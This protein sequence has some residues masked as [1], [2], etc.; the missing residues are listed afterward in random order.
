M[1]SAMRG[2]SAEADFGLFD[3]TARDQMDMFSE[4][5]AT[6]EVDAV[7]RSAA[8]EMREALEADGDDFTASIQMEDGSTRSMSASQWLDE[9]D[10]E[11]DFTQIAELCAP[12]RGGSA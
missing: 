9:L 11:E 5:G 4:G 2:G 7:N 8:R 6:K 12:N 10:A 3:L 1:R